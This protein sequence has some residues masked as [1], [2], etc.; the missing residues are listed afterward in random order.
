MFDLSLTAVP[1]DT[2]S[3]WEERVIG[4]AVTDPVNPLTSTI[5]VQLMS[6]LLLPSTPS[7]SFVSIVASTLVP[8]NL[9]NLC[10]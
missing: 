6:V 1:T 3:A 10:E 8:L 9:P 4:V 2:A 5:G 7:N